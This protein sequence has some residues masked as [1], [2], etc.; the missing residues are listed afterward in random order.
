M[1]ARGTSARGKRAQGDECERDVRKEDESDRDEREGKQHERAQRERAQHER[2]QRQGEERAST[3]AKGRE[4]GEESARD[5]CEGDERAGDEREGDESEGDERK[6]DERERNESERDKREGEERAEAEREREER[7]E[8]EREGD[9]LTTAKEQ[10]E[11]ASILD[12]R[13]VGYQ[14]RFSTS[15][16]QHFTP[17]SG[18]GGGGCWCSSSSP[19]PFTHAQLGYRDVAV[20]EWDKVE[21]Q[22]STR[23]SN[24]VINLLLFL[25]PPPQHLNISSDKNRKN[26]LKMPVL[27]KSKFWC[28]NRV[29]WSGCMPTVMVAPITTV[30]GTSAL[31]LTQRNYI[32]NKTK[33]CKY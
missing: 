2:E 24:A 4:R 33:Y 29:N 18:G 10:E 11:R 23:L 15:A 9:H 25:H 17:L 12:P 8:K 31:P 21:R 22:G 26:S 16:L 14:V 19:P 30:D 27:K 5:E 20:T 7:A 3:S 28:Q 6:G 32:L 1:S 13:A